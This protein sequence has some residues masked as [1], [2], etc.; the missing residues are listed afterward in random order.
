MMDCV[1]V[2]DSIGVG[3]SGFTPCALAA[4]VGRTSRDQAARV[5]EI[6][7]DKV[8]ISLGSNDIGDPHLADHLRKLRAKITA[9]QVTWI[10]P[11]SWEPASVVK[12]VAFEWHDGWI[13]LNGNFATKDG[14]HPS[15]TAMLADWAMKSWP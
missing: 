13:A 4:Q 14:V 15:N 2:G 8:I 12:R 5:Q 3:I 9:R 6:S 1:V 10:L 11:Y 7:F